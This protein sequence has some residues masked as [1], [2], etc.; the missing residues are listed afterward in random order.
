MTTEIQLR[1]IILVDSR[2]QDVATL[3]KGMPS[4]AEVVYLNVSEAGLQQIASVLGERGDVGAVHVLAH[5][6][7]GL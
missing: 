5:G 6:S 7:A 3:L 4:G 2:V 1:E